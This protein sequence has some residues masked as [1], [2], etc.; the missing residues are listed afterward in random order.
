MPGKDAVYFIDDGFGSTWAEFL[1]FAILPYA[2]ERIPLV[3][4]HQLRKRRTQALA[5]ALRKG[6]NGELLYISS[7]DVAPVSY[8]DKPKEKEGAVED[9]AYA[10][11]LC[12]RPKIQVAKM[13]N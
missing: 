6:T 8:D 4:F 2:D 10:L 11:S 3:V 5:H 12:F 7:C 9:G 1:K 13:M